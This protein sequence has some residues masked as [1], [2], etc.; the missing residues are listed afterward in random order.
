MAGHVGKP[1]LN[2]DAEGCLQSSPH[3]QPH[4]PA[5]RNEAGN[6]GRRTHTK[7]LTP[8]EKATPNP[9][10]KDKYEIEADLEAEL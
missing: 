7:Q 2:R 8:G 6:L 10:L 9:R 1:H 3:A 5:F 4:K